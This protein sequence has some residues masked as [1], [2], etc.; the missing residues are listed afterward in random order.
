MTSF[1]SLGGNCAVAF[2]LHQKGYTIRYPFDWC[3]MSIYQLNQ[4]LENNFDN[5]H[6]LKIIKLSE[7]HQNFETFE[8]E[9][10]ILKNNYN[11]KFAHEISNKYNLTD[12]QLILQRRINRFNKLTNPTFIRLE[13]R[14]IS[15]K[16]FITQY[17]KLITNLSKYFKKFTLIIISEN[18][19]F[20]SNKNI[21]FINFDTF[22]KD[23]KYPKINW[24]KIFNL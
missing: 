2:Q 13:T 19:S 5:F 21:K 23:W 20:S 10:Y 18:T 15:N 9:S 16:Y 24:N 4:V 8:S 12:F 1:I 11:I 7:S 14:N 17:Q 22:S 3:N 6:R